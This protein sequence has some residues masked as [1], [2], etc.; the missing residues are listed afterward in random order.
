MD[1]VIYE[2]ELRN[3][4]LNRYIAIGGIGVHWNQRMVGDAIVEGATTVVQFNP[5]VE[6]YVELQ[7]LR[8]DV[9][10]NQ[11]LSPSLT[12]MDLV[13]LTSGIGDFQKAQLYILKPD[14]DSAVFPVISDPTHPSWVV[15]SSVGVDPEGNNL[16]VI[17]IFDSVNGEFLG[18]GTHPPYTALSIGGPD[19]GDIPPC[20]AYYHDWMI[21]ARD[22]FDDMGYST[23]GIDVATAAEIQGHVESSF[24]ALFYELNHG[25]STSFHNICPDS[26]AGITGTDVGTWINDYTKMPFAFIGSCGGLCSNGPGTF[27]YEFRK[28]DTVGTAAIGYCHMDWTG[29]GSQTYDCT[30]CW[31]NSI[32]W[33]DNLFDRLNNGETVED[34]FNHALADYPMCGD[35]SGCMRLDGDPNLALVPA[36]MRGSLPTSNAGTDQI[37]EQTSLAGT[38]ATLDGSSSSS[39]NNADLIYTWSWTGG[40][41]SGVNPTASFPLG[42]S[43]VT[44]TVD[45]GYGSPLDEAQRSDTVSIT[46]VDTTP[47]VFDFIPAD[48]TVEQSTAAGTPVTLVATATDI[49]DA[50]PVITSD[51]PAIFPLGSTTVTFTATDAS[52]NI[53]SATTTVTVVDTTPPDITS[54]SVDPNVLWPPNHKMVP[55]TIAVSVTD[56]CDAAPSC[57][58]D[59]VSS[60]E[61]ENGL[62][63]G[64]TAPDWS[65]TGDFNVNLRAERSGKGSGRVYTIMM[66]CTDDSGNSATK[67]VEVTVPSNK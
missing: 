11:I 25:G 51:A 55:V 53:S 30:Q 15:Y 5:A 34:A 41:A 3:I 26:A 22:G 61:P 40:S 62:G 31:A 49:C 44:L 39:P 6:E 58:V 57:Q 13:D 54:V 14:S 23:E 12:E 28:A 9:V 18:Y 19:W 1:D 4:D 38:L 65:I 27:S 20:G 42:T 52:G 66:Q 17:S 45:D 64:D 56:I 36:V 63:D 60:N 24:T 48:V 10:D 33:Q 32:P 67:D 29:S 50:S 35:G 46:I 59:W 8:P 7:S 16:L 37:L 43:T 2:Y 21:S 47:P